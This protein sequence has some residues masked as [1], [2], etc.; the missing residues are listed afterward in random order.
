ML[1]KDAKAQL[2][3]WILLLQG[4]DLEIRDKKGIKN[5]ITD[6]L[7]CIPNVSCN[8]F[9]IVDNLSNEQLLVASRKS[10]FAD[11]VNYLSQIEHHLIGQNKMST[12]SYLKSGIFLGVTISF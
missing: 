12:G 2:I 6:H 1:K 7:S 11:I 8:E 4:F 10:W 9:P 3:H 5:S